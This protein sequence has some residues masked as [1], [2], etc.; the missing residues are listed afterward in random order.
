MI[1]GCRGWNTIHLKEG[2]IR[3]NMLSLRKQEPLPG[4]STAQDRRHVNKKMCGQ[5]KL[6]RAE[7]I[8]S[9]RKW[10]LPRSTDGRRGDQNED[11]LKTDCE[12]M[13]VALPNPWAL[14]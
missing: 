9:W 8:T 11:S 4:G 2:L 6:G 1:F 12:G 3:K 5:S 7:K 10:L 14:F 13:P